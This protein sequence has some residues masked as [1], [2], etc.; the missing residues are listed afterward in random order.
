VPGNAT[1]T[2]VTKSEIK[3]GNVSQLTGLVPGFGQTGVNGVKAY[4]N[5][6]NNSGGVCG[7]KLTL[8]TADDRFQSATNRNETEKL[9]NQT[10]AFVGNTSV[11]DDGGAPVIDAK[12]I[13]DISLGTTPP[14]FKAKMNFSPNPIDPTASS[15]G[16]FRILNYFKSTEGVKSAA[17]FYQD[18]AVAASQVPR[19]EEDFKQAGIPVVKKYAV[20][21][22][23][24]NFRS[25][26]TDMKQRKV[27]LVITIAEIGAIA[28]LAKAFDDV[29]YFPKVPF[30][31]AQSYGQKLIQ[32]AGPA[33]EG[34]EIGLI[35]AVP[36]EKASVPGMADFDTWYKRTAG[37]ADADFFA[38][39]SWVA[40]SMFVEALKA[41]G[42]DPT[43]AKI[44]AHM[45]HVTSYTGGGIVAPINPAQKKSTP[46]FQV[47]AVKGGKWV[48]QYP[49]KG[50][51]C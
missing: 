16:I 43:Q 17:I 21:I 33:A 41:A 11:V 3:V 26:A 6:V 39:L 35:F 38:V 13:A 7:R 40:A 44:V 27:D 31:G 42:P 20:A 22:N 47:L 10:I 46:C 15:N 49:A 34:T 23:A 50:F 36:E 2:G 25:E 5:M 51:A 24:T 12:P 18:A 8:V 4:F 9:A 37:G 30:Y 32:L 14:R 19:Y 28:N 29:D 1:S 48:K 45:Q